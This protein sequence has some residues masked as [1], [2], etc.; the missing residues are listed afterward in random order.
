MFASNANDKFRLIFVKRSNF[1]KILKNRDETRQRRLCLGS[2]LGLG[3]ALSR[4]RLVK[5]RSVSSRSRLVKTRRD[6][7]RPR[8]FSVS[9]ESLQISS[10]DCNIQYFFAVSVTPSPIFLRLFE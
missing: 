4:S 8:H 7:T 6:E 3:W 10:F 5:E 9:V 1:L 2:R